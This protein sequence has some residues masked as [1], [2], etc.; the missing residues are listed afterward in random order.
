MN[1]ITREFLPSLLL[2]TVAYTFCFVQILISLVIW[3]LAKQIV[4]TSSRHIMARRVAAISQ[5]TEREP[6]LEL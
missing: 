2:F 4:R 1:Y 6:V 3:N 5:Q